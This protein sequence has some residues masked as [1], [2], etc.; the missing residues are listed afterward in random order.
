MGG[1]GRREGGAHGE[2]EGLVCLDDEGGR[3]GGTASLGVSRGI[4]PLAGLA[5]TTL[6][7]LG[8]RLG[9]PA[10]LVEEI[11]EFAHG[12]IEVGISR[13][14]GIPRRRSAHVGSSP[15]LE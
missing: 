11:V 13:G 14:A 9:S 12:G 8:A 1:L 4:G 2:A 10:I 6:S 15:G 5:F 3:T 7:F